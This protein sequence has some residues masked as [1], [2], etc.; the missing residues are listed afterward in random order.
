[1]CGA[2]TASLPLAR[3]D[4]IRFDHAGLGNAV[5]GASRRSDHFPAGYE[6]S[7]AVQQ[8]MCSD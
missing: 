6:F 2:K 1:M 3:A 8:Q 5:I 4:D 7:T